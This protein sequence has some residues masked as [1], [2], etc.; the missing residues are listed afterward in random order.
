VLASGAVTAQVLP[1]VQ[2]PA[3][4]AGHP[5]KAPL[6]VLDA[7]PKTAPVVVARI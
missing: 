6:R 3:P 7:A 4:P 1:R 2:L 5:D